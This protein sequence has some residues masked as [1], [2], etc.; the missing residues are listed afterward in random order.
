MKGRP[1]FTAVQVKSSLWSEERK[2]DGIETQSS[3]GRTLV[4]DSGSGEARKT[5][6]SDLAPGSMAASFTKIENTPSEFSWPNVGD[7]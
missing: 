7:E 2:V 3:T 1:A 4:I 5:W 6:A